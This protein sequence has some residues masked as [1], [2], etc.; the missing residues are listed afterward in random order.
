MCKQAIAII[1]E[2]GG[3][4]EHKN[5]PTVPEKDKQLYAS[6]SGYTANEYFNTIYNYIHGKK[7]QKKWNGFGENNGT[8]GIRRKT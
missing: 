5:D 3:T 4:D 7:W 8:T 2:V 6:G 1:V